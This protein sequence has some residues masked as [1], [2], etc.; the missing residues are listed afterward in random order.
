MFIPVVFVLLSDALQIKGQPWRP[1]LG[2]LRLRHSRE[3]RHPELISRQTLPRH[4]AAYAK[5]GGGLLQLV[6]PHQPEKDQADLL[7]H[8]DF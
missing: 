7:S 3:V 2:V 5:P 8:L 6:A 1:V 4:D